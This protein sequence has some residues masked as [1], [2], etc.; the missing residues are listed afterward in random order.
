MNALR[1]FIGRLPKAELHIH[2]E[3][4]LEPG[5]AFEIGRRNGIALPYSS[6]A[7]LEAAYDFESLQDFLR[8]YC[9]L[10]QVLTEERDFYDLT[11][12]YLARA[13]SQNVLHAE[14]FFDPQAHTGRGVPF[15]AVIEGI[16]R[17]RMDAARALGI[18]SLAIMCFLRDS[19]VADAMRTLEEALA[20]KDRIIAVGLDSAEAG[21]P[22]GKFKEVFERAR[23]EGF[24]TVAHAGEEGPPDYVLEALTELHVARIDHGVRSM[25][26]EALVRRL[27]EM[28]IPLTVC[29]LSN[30]KLGVVSEMKS[31]PLREMIEKGLFV[32]IN[33]DDPAFFGGYV[34]ENYEA[35]QEAFGFT[36]RQLYGLARNS[37]EA[38][39]LRSSEKRA[40]IARLD[41]CAA[42][43]RGVLEGG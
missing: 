42:S 22:P 4:A 30:V 7:E 36:A 32:T 37:F 1:R 43:N 3:G 16:S 35:V 34:N 27:A 2:I 23:G 40:L 20:Y 14:M 38:S 8:V 5:L 19:T 12:A 31:H 24:R 11:Y 13:H 25:E 39:F 21:N 33:S 15:A 10:A 9:E 29:P 17:A 18:R 26:D 6:E 28:K 41:E